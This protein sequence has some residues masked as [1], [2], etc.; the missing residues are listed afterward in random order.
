VTAP[1][2]RPLTARRALWLILQRPEQRTPE[3]QHRLAHLTTQQAALADAIA[4]AQAFAQLVR[5]RQAPQRDPW[6]AR[7]A[8]SCVT[9]RQRF[10]KGLHD[11][12]EAV[13]AEGTVPWRISLMEGHIHRLQTRTRQMLGRAT[14]DLLPQRF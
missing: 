6:L 7:A 10:A 4:L 11:D 13:N 8:E 2:L 5:H 3:E 1:R 9:S 14:R 12:D